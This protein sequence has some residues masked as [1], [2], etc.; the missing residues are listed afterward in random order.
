MQDK[1]AY[2][3]DS[4]EAPF[5]VELIAGREMSLSMDYTALFQ[6]LRVIEDNYRLLK[7]LDVLLRDS[8]T[9]ELSD[10]ELKIGLRSCA[11]TIVQTVCR[12]LETP[13]DRHL[14]R[15]NCIYTRI[16]HNIEREDTK[17]AA[18]TQHQKLVEQPWYEQLELVRN[19]RVSHQEEVAFDT[20]SVPLIGEF[21]TN[22]E[23][24]Q[25]VINA[26][27]ELLE[28]CASANLNGGRVSYIFRE[29]P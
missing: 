15:T 28:F 26:I 2:L 7:K 23:F 9:N 16:H 24:M 6:D 29:H 11:D 19:K 17:Q 14:K 4:S 22:P 12:L 21:L 8:N 13:N 18:L 25:Y 20:Y 3:K 1:Y 5:K 27:K 10:V